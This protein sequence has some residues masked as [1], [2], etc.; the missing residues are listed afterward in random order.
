MKK[1]EEAKK[2]NDL[3]MEKKL[4]KD[5]KEVQKYLSSIH[6]KGGELRKTDNTSDTIRKSISKNIRGCLKIMENEHHSLWLH[7]IDTIKNKKGYYSY[8]PGESIH[9][10]IS[11]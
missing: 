2:N 4:L 6:R 1:L 9:W 3:G 8:S 7:L 5:L 11:S 10:N